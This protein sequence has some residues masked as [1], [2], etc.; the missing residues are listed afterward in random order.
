MS[1]ITVSRDSFSHGEE[2]AKSVAKQLG[3]DCIGP[4]GVYKDM[5]EES[6]ADPSKADTEGAHVLTD[7]K[8]QA[9]FRNAFYKNMQRDNVVYYGLA[10]HV[11]LSDMPNVLKVRLVADTEDRVAEMSRRLNITPEE[12]RERILCG[13]QHCYEWDSQLMIS[14][15]GA[16]TFD[17]SVNLHTLDV[18][19]AAKLIADAARMIMD[20]P[21]DGLQSMLTDLA[22]ASRIELTLLDHFADARVEMKN[23]CAYIQVEAS[24][25]QEEAAARK[26][27]RALSNIEG[28]REVHVGVIP[29]AFVPF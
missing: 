15:G 26:A 5:C 9:M 18:E 10:G 17:L 1:I 21:G 28:I 2:I 29:S 4:D 11:F 6:G 7:R 25:V 19:R 23:G 13:D 12:A 8:A 24:I 22:L 27:M 16:N 20:Q 3:Y 14:E